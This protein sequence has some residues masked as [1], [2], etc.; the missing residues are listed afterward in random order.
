MLSS[1]G[2]KGKTAWVVVKRSVNGLDGEPLKVGQKVQLSL[3]QAHEAVYNGTA[4]FCD[5]PAAKNAADGGKGSGADGA[6]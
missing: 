2:I 3:A 1:G 4:E 5:P 6:K